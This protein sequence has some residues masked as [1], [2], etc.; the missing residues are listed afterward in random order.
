MALCTGILYAQQSMSDWRVIGGTDD[1]AVFYDARGVRKFSNGH[2]E[3]WLKVLPV[4]AITDSKP[5][6]KDRTARGARKLASG[7]VPPMWLDQKASL[8]Q[9][10]DAII[11][12]EVANE[13]AIQP[14]ARMLVELDCPN[15]L[16]RELSVWL[17][18]NGKI[19]SDDKPSEWHHIAPETNFSRLHMDVC[20]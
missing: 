8:D 15:R 4:K 6:D 2:F 20:R 16:S 1:S 11:L 13:A 9:I 17:D 7:Y 12:E 3:V 10:T 5:V 19:Q 14:N 18:L